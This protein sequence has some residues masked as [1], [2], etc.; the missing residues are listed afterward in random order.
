MVQGVYYGR[1]ADW[2]A[3]A[4]VLLQMITATTPL[5]L[6]LR[7]QLNV[8]VN[9]GRSYSTFAFGPSTQQQPLIT[10]NDLTLVSPALCLQGEI[11]VFALPSNTLSLQ[12]H[13]VNMKRI[14]TL[15]SLS[16]SLSPTRDSRECV[17]CALISAIN[18]IPALLSSTFLVTHP[19]TSLLREILQQVSNYICHTS[20]LPH[21]SLCLCGC[22]FR[23]TIIASVVI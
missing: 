1:E 18:T 20:T 12:T 11:F 10:N 22:A 4:I 17:S 21:V 2:W 5:T 23:R 16:L 13:I 9:E 3:F 15:Q 8:Q 7:E 6:I 14:I 19:V